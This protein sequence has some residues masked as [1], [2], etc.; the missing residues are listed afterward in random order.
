M[1]RKSWIVKVTSQVTSDELRL[2][3]KQLER[4][5]DK[6]DDE[7]AK[8]LNESVVTRQDIQLIEI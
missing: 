1:S 2:I 8:K 6:L 3:G 4:I 7:Q 5:H